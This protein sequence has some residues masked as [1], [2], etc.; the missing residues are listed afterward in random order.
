VKS[1][2]LATNLLLEQ[3]GTEPVARLLEDAGC[4]GRTSL[5][6]GIEDVAARHAGLDNLVTAHDLARV[7]SGVA[8]RT[9]AGVATCEEIEEVLSRQEHRDKIPAGLPP[10]TYVANKTG[11]VPGVSHDA[12][13]VRPADAAPYVLVVC[14]TADVPEEQATA[15]IASIS[16][17]A[18][19]V[20]ER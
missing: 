4:S 1:G 18:W 6:R 8:S 10:G 5:R 15:L 2:N 9:L 7:L 19:E 13:L 16:A 20:R 14:T 17:V 11:W 12:A 3:V